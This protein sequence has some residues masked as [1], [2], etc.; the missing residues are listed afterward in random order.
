MDKK[1]IMYKED[2]NQLFSLVKKTEQEVMAFK[3]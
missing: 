3:L 1:Y 2:R